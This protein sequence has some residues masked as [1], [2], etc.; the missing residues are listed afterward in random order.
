[1]VPGLRRR[2]RRS[3][4]PTGS[5]VLLAYTDTGVGGVAIFLR[6]V[7]ACLLACLLSLGAGFVLVFYLLW[8]VKVVISR[9]DGYILDGYGIWL[10]KGRMEW[11]T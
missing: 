10:M 11:G 5:A 2:S 8:G 3:L 4:E 6:L 7:L 9:S 1:M